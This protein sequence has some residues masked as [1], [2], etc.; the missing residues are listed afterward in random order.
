MRLLIALLAVSA[1]AG[2]QLVRPGIAERWTAGTRPADRPVRVNTWS[3]AQ[4]VIRGDDVVPSGAVLLV[5]DSLTDRFQGWRTLAPVVANYGVGG[6]TTRKLLRTLPNYRAIQRAR[7]VVLTMGTNDIRLHEVDGIEE[8][9]RTLSASIPVPLVWN[10]IPPTHFGD[11]DAVNVAA[12][13]VCAER[14]DCT[15]LVVDFAPSDFLDGTHLTASGYAKWVQALRPEL[16]SQ[17]ALQSP[18]RY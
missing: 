15:F 5:G 3:R 6:M 10:A 12:R 4:R 14:P 17:A 16:A 9:F 18:R 7:L 1:L 13:K 11:R 2:L 8:R